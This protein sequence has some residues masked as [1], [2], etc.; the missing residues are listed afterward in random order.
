[1]KI[2]KLINILIDK[3]YQDGYIVKEIILPNEWKK[4]LDLI[5]GDTKKP[6]RLITG[7]LP[8]KIFKS[9]SRHLQIIIEPTEKI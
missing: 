5:I 8:L 9:E 6:T 7:A 1:M 3:Y 4:E 2:D